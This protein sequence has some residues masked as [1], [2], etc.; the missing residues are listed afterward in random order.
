MTLLHFFVYLLKKPTPVQEAALKNPFLSYI[1]HLVYKYTFIT[2]DQIHINQ[3]DVLSLLI[4][5]LS[6]ML[7]IP[8]DA[9]GDNLATEKTQ[10]RVYPAKFQINFSAGLK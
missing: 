5:L 7:P 6:K 9:R 2:P 8:P 1:R 4:I 10:R 3:G